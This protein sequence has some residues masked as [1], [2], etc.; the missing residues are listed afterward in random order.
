LYAAGFELPKG[1]ADSGSKPWIVEFL[2]INGLSYK[3]KV[4][5]SDPDRG[6]GIV[7]MTLEAYK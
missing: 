2:D 1:I 4:S 3:F 6:M 7:T 5:Q